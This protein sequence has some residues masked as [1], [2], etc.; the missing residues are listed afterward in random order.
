MGLSDR[1]HQILQELEQQFPAT[2]VAAR[3]RRITRRLGPWA[4][5]LGWLLLV[6]GIVGVFALL[7]SSVLASFGSLL[8]A[9]VGLGLLIQ[10]PISR[11][12]R[13]LRTQLHVRDGDDT[14][15][16]DAPTDV[17]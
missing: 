16:G 8:A 12:M 14:R 7:A 5:R 11:V 3:I 13:R 17:C 6:V 15:N 10:G 9:I 1:E 4:D 2:G